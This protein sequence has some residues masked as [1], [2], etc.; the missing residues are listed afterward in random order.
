MCQKLGIRIIAASSLDAKGRV[1]R[2]NGVHQ[3]RL[4]MKMRRKGIT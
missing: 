3:D 2:M 1:E 4:I